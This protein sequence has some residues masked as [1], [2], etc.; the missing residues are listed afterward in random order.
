LEGVLGVV[1]VAQHAPTDT[2]DHRAMPPHESREG[3]LV[4][5][6]GKAFQ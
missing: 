5:L 2:Q 1:P 3:D 4:T 6:A